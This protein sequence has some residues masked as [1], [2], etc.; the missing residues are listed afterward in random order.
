MYKLLQN[1]IKL[2]SVKLEARI[3]AQEIAQLE[4]NIEWVD[5]LQDEWGIDALEAVEL[6]KKV[7][8]IKEALDEH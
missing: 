5:K 2:A 4:A 3:K 6:S 7:S 1:I 8:Q